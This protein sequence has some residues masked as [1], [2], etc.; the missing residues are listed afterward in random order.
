VDHISRTY[1]F[2]TTFWS[3]THHCW[4]RCNDLPKISRKQKPFQSE[5]AKIY[6]LYFSSHI[7]TNGCGVVEGRLF[8]FLIIF[9]VL[10]QQLFKTQDEEN[11]MNGIQE[12]GIIRESEEETDTT[13]SE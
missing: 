4:P 11:Q 13:T 7:D 3:W 12:N 5:C 6:S 10:Q 9:L 8:L 1:H 2:E